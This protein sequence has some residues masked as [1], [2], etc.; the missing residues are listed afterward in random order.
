MRKEANLGYFLSTIM[1]KTV[2]QNTTYLKPGKVVGK[3]LKWDNVD[4]LDKEKI[5][6]LSKQSA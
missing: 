1:F 3:K 4:E 6:T 2:R 5:N